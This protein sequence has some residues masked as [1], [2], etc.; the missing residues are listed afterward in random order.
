M[1]IIVFA[2]TV[3]F[4][5]A[6]T[7]SDPRQNNI[8]PGDWV[9]MLNP[10]DEAALEEALRIKDAAPETQISVVSLGAPSAQAGLRRCLAMGADRASHILYSD[11]NE[12]DSWA[13]ATILAAQARRMRFDLILCGRQAIDSNAGL[14]GPY[15]AAQLEIPH[16]SR[17]IKLAEP[18]GGGRITA[19]RRLDRGDREIIEC[20][21]PA[22]LTVE[23]DINVARIPTLPAM[24][25]AAK[26]PIEKCAVD[27]LEPAPALNRSKTIRLTKPK[28]KRRAE[29]QLSAALSPAD[30]MK[31][32]MKGGGAAAPAKDASLLE[33]CSEDVLEE[34]ERFLKS[35]GAR[36]KP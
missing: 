30:R 19:E 18:G 13:S 33:G 12:L 21:A 4:L 9:D 23:Q 15:L 22:L 29:K 36:F 1:N 3:R 6:Q 27:D 34:F 24:L 7:G 16:M 17:V 5:Q 25:A 26:L 10:F 20:A 28:A 32:M 35:S 8:A 11:Y 31:A 14:V 2:K